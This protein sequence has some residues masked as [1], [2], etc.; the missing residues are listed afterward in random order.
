MKTQDLLNALMR[1][2]GDNPS[3]LASRVGQKPR[4]AQIVNFLNGA[5]ISPRPATFQSIA[6]LY[7]VPVEVF[8]DSELAARHL[9]A[10]QPGAAAPSALRMSQELAPHRF[11]SVDE[12]DRAQ[13]SDDAT[14]I[15]LMFDKLP[16]ELD[17]IRIHNMVL[18]A[19]LK[20]LSDD[21]AARRDAP[22][23]LLPARHSEE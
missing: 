16:T 14:E 12:K 22:G 21:A 3:S 20:V 17:R 23:T 2:H 9:A 6:D 19:I 13:L 15:G 8:F 18:A 1:L 5:T 4:K 7:Q 11:M 10:M